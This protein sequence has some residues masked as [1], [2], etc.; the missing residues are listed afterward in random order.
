M[1]TEFLSKSNLR[2]GKDGTKQI[3]KGKS[4]IPKFPKLE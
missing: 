4:L 2:K 3:T 1:D